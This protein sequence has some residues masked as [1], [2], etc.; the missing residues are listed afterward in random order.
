[1]NTYLL[2]LGLCDMVKDDFVEHRVEGRP[3][4][5]SFY[6]EIDERMGNETN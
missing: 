4:D 2:Y 5:Y 1:M 6:E 3:R